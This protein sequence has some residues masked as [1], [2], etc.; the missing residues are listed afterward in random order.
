MIDIKELTI[1][2]RDGA[3]PKHLLVD[4]R[5]RICQTCQH[6]VKM[7]RQ[8]G[9]CLCFIDLKTRMIDQTCPMDKW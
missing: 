1:Q 7:T 4:K 3:A 6:L 2:V 8:C 5:K 9:K